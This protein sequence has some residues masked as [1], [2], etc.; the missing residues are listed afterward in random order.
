[1]IVVFRCVLFYILYSESLSKRKK[2]L[3]GIDR[4]Y[5]YVEKVKK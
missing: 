4:I 2:M 3:L 1:M 5:F